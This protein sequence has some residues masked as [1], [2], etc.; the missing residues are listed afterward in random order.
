MP[1]NKKP[2]NAKPNKR[3]RKIRMRL[4]EEPSKVVNAFSSEKLKMNSL[5][6][7]KKIGLR[8]LAQLEDYANYMYADCLRKANNGE[9]E[10]M[11]RFLEAMAEKQR[12]LIAEQ[13]RK[14]RLEREN[15][16][17]ERDKFVNKTNKGG[18]NRS[19]KKAKLDEGLLRLAKKGFVEPTKK[20][21]VVAEG[22]ALKLSREIQELEKNPFVNRD[23]LIKLKSAR[24]TLI[25]Y[26]LGR[27]ERSHRLAEYMETLK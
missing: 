6:K 9:K 17:I 19:V 1:L 3:V 27:L 11:K 14:E 15:K 16:S 2:V 4:G 24:E 10:Q 18:V 5:F 23:R 12:E 22:I 21:T 25:N 26:M 20:G 7:G 13:Q 8:Q